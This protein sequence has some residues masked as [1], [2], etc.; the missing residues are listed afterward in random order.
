ML[1]PLR[2]RRHVVPLK[3]RVPNGCVKNAAYP[4]ILKEVAAITSQRRHRNVDAATRVR[5]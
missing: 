4:E 3:S 2:E 5:C 1:Q